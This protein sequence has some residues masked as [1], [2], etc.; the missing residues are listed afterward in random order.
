MYATK[1]VHDT[2]TTRSASDAVFLPTHFGNRITLKVGCCFG[3]ASA[4]STFDSG[5]CSYDTLKRQFATAFEQK[6]PTLLAD[7]EVN[8]RVTIEGV[9]QTL[10]EEK[11]MKYNSKDVWTIIGCTQR[12]KRRSWIN[13]NQTIKHCNEHYH[14]HRIVCVEVN[15]EKTSN[16]LDQLVLHRSLDVLV[17]IHGAQVS[18]DCIIEKISL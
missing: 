3:S 7:V 9:I 4:C 17:G 18:T 14:S 13:L 1:I 12:L 5:S 2:K 10:S 11:R 8:R 6:Y 15:V 16:P